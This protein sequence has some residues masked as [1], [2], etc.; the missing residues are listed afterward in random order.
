[1]IFS[2]NKSSIIQDRIQHYTRSRSVVLSELGKTLFPIEPFYGEIKEFLKGYLNVH[3]DDN[4]M[5][6]KNYIRSIS[7]PYNIIIKDSLIN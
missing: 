5:L 4:E 3:K 2:K 7:Y 1:V 6:N